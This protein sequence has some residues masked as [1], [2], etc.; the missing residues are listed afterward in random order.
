[1]RG[2]KYGAPAGAGGHSGMLVDE[3]NTIFQFSKAPAGDG[4]GHNGMFFKG[5]CIMLKRQI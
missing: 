4:G 2:K 1:M 5:E 3:Q